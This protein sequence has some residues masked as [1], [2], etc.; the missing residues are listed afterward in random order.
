V[1]ALNTTGLFPGM[2][3]TGPGVPAG[4]TITSIGP[5]GEVVL[6]RPVT[7]ASVSPGASLSINLGFWNWAND[8]IFVDSY[9][10][11]FGQTFGNFN[12]SE[13]AQAISNKSLANVVDVELKP[14][15]VFRLTDISLKHQY[16]AN[17]YAGSASTKGTPDQVGLLW[18]PL[19]S[20]SSPAPPRSIQNWAPVG[21]A[22]QF[23]LT[24]APRAKS[25]APIFVPEQIGKSS[26]QG[27]T[28][29]AG[30]AYAVS[31]VTLNDTGSK[32]AVFKGY[33]YKRSY[34]VGISLNYSFTGGSTDGSQ[35]QILLNGKLY[36]AMTGSLAESSILPDSGELSA[37]FGIGKE[38]TG[39][40]AHRIEI[41]LVPR[42]AGGG[43]GAGT[44][45][46]VTV[47]QFDVFTL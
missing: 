43:R 35:L 18:S 26:V 3:V 22:K 8:A 46:T 37:T 9:G 41:R 32:M 39:L 10:S 45:T 44:P 12:V 47:S 19:V 30:P 33:F 36:F 4:T 11:Y 25:V 15:K 27:N 31:A 38:Y 14:A 1:T 2:G 29:I 20:G 6:S 42:P 16:A 21:P 5:T 23:V 7:A 34:Q 17:W 24:P 40:G 13:P 28:T